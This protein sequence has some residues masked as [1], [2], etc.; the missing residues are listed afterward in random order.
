MSQIAWF[1]QQVDYNQRVA[2]RDDGWK[3]TE[4]RIKAMK[5]MALYD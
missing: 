3:I 1:S 5:E 2:Q 4:K